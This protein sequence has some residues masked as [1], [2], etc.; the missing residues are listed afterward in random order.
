MTR[1]QHDVTDRAYAQ[2][3]EALIELE[4]AIR[5]VREEAAVEQMRAETRDMEDGL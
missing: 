1:G 2:L 4:R 5:R 3:E